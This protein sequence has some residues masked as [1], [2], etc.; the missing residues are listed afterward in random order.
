[1]RLRSWKFGVV[2]L[3][4]NLA[5]AIGA[6]I[7]N[8]YFVIT[9]AETFVQD[10]LLPGARYEYIKSFAD[11][12]VEAERRSFSLSRYPVYGPGESRSDREELRSVKEVLAFRSS[13]MTA[14]AYMVGTFIAAE[15]TPIPGKGLRLILRV[16]HDDSLE[17]GLTDR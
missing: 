1:V 14:N 17:I 4:L 11:G 15:P 7:A 9:R 2:T 16:D 12:S 5:L 13:L 10:L 6:V 3:G 8:R